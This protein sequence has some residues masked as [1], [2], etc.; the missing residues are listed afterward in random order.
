VARIDHKKLCAAAHTLKNM[1]EKDGMSFPGVG[2]PKQ[3]N[4]RLFRLAIGT[5]SSPRAE[6]RRQ[7]GDAGGVSS[8]VATINVVAADDRAN[9]FLGDVVELVGG[10]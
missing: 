8:P 9:K 3:N 2:A 1:M 5:C 6:D 7:T 4:V 10:L